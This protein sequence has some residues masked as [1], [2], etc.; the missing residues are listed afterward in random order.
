MEYELQCFKNRKCSSEAKKNLL[1]SKEREI[2][3]KHRVIVK[4]RSN[5]VR[6]Y[7]GGMADVNFIYYNRE[8]LIFFYLILTFNKT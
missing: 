6:K 5:F 1:A 4:Y 3:Y 2:L 7:N 8:R